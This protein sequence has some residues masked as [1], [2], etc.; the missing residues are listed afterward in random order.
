MSRS[1]LLLA[2]LLPLATGCPKDA[3]VE[4]AVD[5]APAAPAGGVVGG[6]PA[7]TSQ[8]PQAAEPAPVPVELSAEQLALVERV[9]QEG[10]VVQLTDAG[11]EPRQ[12]L[13]IKAPVGHKETV[14]MSMAMTMSMEMGAMGSHTMAMPPFLT[15]MEMEVIE[16][17]PDD[18]LRMVAETV[19]VGVGEGPEPLDPML[20]GELERSL[21]E[22]VGMK[23]YGTMDRQGRSA[24]VEVELP[25]GVSPE[26]REQFDTM[27]NTFSQLASP[28]PIEAV[29]PGAAWDTSMVM[30]NNGLKLL[31]TV[32]YE[33][34]EVSGDT[35][36]LD[37]TYTQALVSGADM[38]NLPPGAEVEWLRFASQGQGRSIQNLS[39]LTPHDVQAQVEAD[40]LVR[41]SMQGMV[42]EM[43]MTMAMDMGLEHLED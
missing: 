8:L 15:D 5:P 40:M 41:I 39:M 42:Q 35:L 20:L 29:G 1:A 26:M 19:S 22:I 36:T 12:V 34:V 24:E 32:H 10:V 13:K 30:D 2:L 17:L 6:L 16:V 7:D 23:V 43:G 11:A 9:E 27:N 3:P 38:G 4:P 33:L 21:G 18:R 14:R 37:S 31:Q 28:L 25:E